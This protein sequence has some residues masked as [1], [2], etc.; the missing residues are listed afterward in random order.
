M[1]RGHAL[2]ISLIIGAAAIFG[3]FAATHSIGL[4]RSSARPTISTAAIAAHNRALDRTEANLKRV[5][6]RNQ[7]ARPTPAGTAPQRVIYVRPAP[8][9]V[10]L[11]HGGHESD[12]EHEGDDG[13]GFDD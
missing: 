1:K 12:G 11:H 13:G 5:L 10:T 9:I 2:L 7:V 3:V 8:H 4:G 6:A